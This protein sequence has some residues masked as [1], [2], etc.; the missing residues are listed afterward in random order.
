[1]HIFKTTVFSNSWIALSAAA[2]TWLAYLLYPSALEIAP[3]VLLLFATFARYN[4]IA[5]TLPDAVTGEKFVFMKK[6]RKLLKILFVLAGGISCYFAWQLSMQQLLFLGH[7][8]LLTS[9]YIFPL[10][11]GFTTIQPLR[12]LPYLKIFLIAYVWACSTYIMPLYHELS[13]NLTSLLAF[14]ERFLFLFSITI[15]FDIKDFSDDKRLNLKTIPNTFGIE[16]SK[17]IATICLI[18]CCSIVFMIYPY[19]VS[20]G[21]ILSYFITC[22]LIWYAN[23][24]KP[25]IYYLGWIDGTMIWQFLLVYLNREYLTVFIQ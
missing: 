1:M 17:W 6:N 21:L 8:A 22:P 11:L 13:F 4:I 23:I 18:I 12:K 9:W 5:F 10:P 7:L 14:T 2:S 24:H 20:I 19:T 16:T 15:P 25:A 3:I